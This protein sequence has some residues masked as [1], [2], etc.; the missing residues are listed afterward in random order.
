M[1][2]GSNLVSIP[3][4]AKNKAAAYVFINWLTSA[5]TQT[6][7]NK[8]FGTTPQHSEASSNLSIISKEMQENSTVPFSPEYAV[9][10]KKEFTRNV[11]M[12]R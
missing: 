4:N 1:S 10:V 3:K 6:A 12:T 2:G 11:L 7:L 5:K 9:A 8:Q